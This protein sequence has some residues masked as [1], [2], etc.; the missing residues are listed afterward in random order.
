LVSADAGRIGEERS[1]CL[2]HPTLRVPFIVSYLIQRNSLRPE[3]RRRKVLAEGWGERR[4]RSGIS[5]AGLQ[6]RLRGQTLA[7]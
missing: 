1:K 7:F 5:L 6:A 4:R 3:D 2:R